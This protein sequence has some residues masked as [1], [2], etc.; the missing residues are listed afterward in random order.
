VAATG[1]SDESAFL[2]RLRT[3]L[4]ARLEQLDAERALVR[5]AL[6]ALSPTPPPRRAKRQ[7][8]D[9]ALD[10][11]TND[12][13]IRASMLSLS[14]RCDSAEI[15]AIMNSLEHEGLATRAGLGWARASPK[16]PRTA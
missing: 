6:D 9:A 7:V 3:D 5:R 4:S 8:R 13:G 2:R 1:S 14:L 15:H 16:S 12:P 10:V 11:I